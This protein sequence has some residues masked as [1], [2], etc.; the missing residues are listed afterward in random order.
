MF[1]TGSNF[2][3]PSDDGVTWG[4]LSNCVWDAPQGFNGRQLKKFYDNGGMKECSFSTTLE[5]RDATVEAVIKDLTTK[6][7]SDTYL[8]AASLYIVRKLENSKDDRALL[9]TK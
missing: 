2:L 7:P 6:T 3:L 5:L 1:R 8:R 4:N 9:V